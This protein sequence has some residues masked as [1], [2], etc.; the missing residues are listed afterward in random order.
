MF[1]HDKVPDLER[2]K[3]RGAQRDEFWKGLGFRVQGFSG[4]GF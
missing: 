4:L 3:P 2:S 1:E